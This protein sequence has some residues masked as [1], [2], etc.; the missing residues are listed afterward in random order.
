MYPQAYKALL[1]VLRNGPKKSIPDIVAMFP[2]IKAEI[3]NNRHQADVIEENDPEGLR[4]E[5]REARNV[6]TETVDH[7]GFIEIDGVM[8]DSIDD[9]ADILMDLD[10]IRKLEDIQGEE[11]VW[12]HYVFGYDSHYGE[13]M[14]NLEDQA[15]W[16][17]MR[18]TGHADAR[19]LP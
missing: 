13:H 18:S 1:S 7:Q 19:Q 9:C 14:K 15:M 11:D 4:L 10:E 3:D 8:H 12:W 5:Y 6:V 16:L 2:A 17:T